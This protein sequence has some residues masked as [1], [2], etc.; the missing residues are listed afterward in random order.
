MLSQEEMLNIQQLNRVCLEEIGS[1][2]RSAGYGV[3]GDGYNIN[4]DS[5]AIYKR[6]AAKIDTVQYFL[7][8]FTDA[9]YATMTGLV[10][11]TSVY[12]LMK[13]SNA[14]APQE[15]A[16]YVTDLRYTE[17]S[18]DLI[19]VTLETITTKRDETFKQNGGFRTFTNTERVALRN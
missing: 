16:D 1:N 11:G 17:I 8:E 4:G 19:A 6:G 10:N 15:F 2:L 9:E 7:K 18:S 13:Q 14:A 3:T 5:L 12:K